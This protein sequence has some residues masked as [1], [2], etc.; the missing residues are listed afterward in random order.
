MNSTKM[1]QVYIRWVLVVVVLL[2][3]G[4]I[5]SGMNNKVQLLPDV[6]PPNVL[7]SVKWPGASENLL[8]TEVIEPYER[9]LTSKLEH[10]QYLTVSLSP[11]KVKFVTTFDFGTDLA[12]AEADIRTLL[13]QIRP[14]PINV[15]PIVYSQGGNNVSNRVVG[16]YFFVSVTNEFSSRQLQIIKAISEQQIANISGID[17]VE[18]NPQLGSRVLFTLD[19]KKMADYAVSFDRV[20]QV[21]KRLFDIPT[22][23]LIQS[24]NAL[25][26]QY[27]GPVQLQ[28]F[29]ST[30]VDF[31]DGTAITLG[32]VATVSIE[33]I[34]TTAAV[35]FNGQK[36]IAVRVL[37]LS[38]ANLTQL[39]Q[40]VQLVLDK[41]QQYLNS[42]GL[43]YQLSYDTTLFIERAI[44][45]LVGS[46]LAGFVLSMLVSYLFFRS[47]APTLLGAGI[48]ILSVCG[49]LILM[50]MLGVSIN[51]ISL[52]GITFAIGMFV[53][54][55][56]IISEYLIRHREKTLL[57]EIK[58]VRQ[59]AP[60]LIASVL[61]TVIVF[62]PLLFNQGGEGQLFSGLAVVIVGGLVLALL[63][64]L[65]IAPIFAFHFFSESAVIQTRES[66]LLNIIA[67][68]TQSW[69]SRIGVLAFFCI[70]GITLGIAVFPPLNY[71][72]SIKRDAIDVFVPL[73]AGLS[74][75]GVEKALVEPLNQAI[76]T[77]AELGEMKNTYV[78]GW[79][80]FVTAALRV[81]DHERIE[82]V[83]AH[84]KATLPAKFPENRVIVMQGNLF[85]GMGD[86]NNIEL[87]LFVRDTRWLA[88]N[89]S[90][91]KKLIEE[92][93]QG[94]RLRFDPDLSHPASRYVMSPKRD[95][96]RDIGVDEGSLKHLLRLIT[97]N[98]YAGLYSREGEAL[99]AYMVLATREELSD[100]GNV[101]FVTDTG[102][103]TYLSA[104]VEFDKR[105]IVPPLKRINGAAVMTIKVGVVDKNQSVSSVVSAL[106]ASVIPPLTQM[107]GDKG[108]I[109]V[110]GSAA[111]LSKAKDFMALMLA[112]LLLAFF[113]IVALVYRS[114]KM[115][116]YVVLTLPFALAGGVVGFNVLNAIEPQGFNILTM[117]GFMIMLGVV[118][119]NGILLIDAIN[120][121]FCRGL[122]LSAAV[123]SGM[124]ERL[125][126]ILVST[127]T[128]VAGMLPLLL[129]QSQAG[130]IYRGLAAVIVGG[131]LANLL[132]VFWVT[133]AAV[134]QF[135]LTNK[136]EENLAAK[137]A[138]Q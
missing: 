54:G 90:A 101:E 66:K 127:I 115:S 61:T 22:G 132:A 1:H 67:R 91:I 39:Q 35:R 18:L 124:Q 129:L 79:G 8:L 72:P 99:K 15:P 64:T 70:G 43:K 59:L 30:P 117:I 60:A 77:D 105:V 56:L 98:D 12:K 28:D 89:Q 88:D 63:L 31:I 122:A 136:Q 51:V 26:L 33:P 96:L 119:N 11:E 57:G 25:Q 135:G 6:E 120:K 73:G 46:I 40:K 84:L 94:I 32:D 50:H 123:D 20:H 103:L 55:V 62:L 87:Q 104:L 107:I 29:A 83:L 125:K 19:P 71:L 38:S 75:A 131:I 42:A 74:V 80:N 68:Y 114:V 36:A 102:Q 92:K 52:A 137:E 78:L 49:T 4:G 27:D 121:A 113:V 116:L 3:V 21:I 16:S 69:F 81:T 106:H 5:Y 93:L 95:N 14:L 7:F 82:T 130:H 85:G 13:S 112:F 134:K 24:D 111:S 34:E 100:Y 48:T 108:Y 47:I 41:N 2:L 65:L 118:S 17:V 138:V 10:L 126:P 86:V 58:R 109:E 133:S 45:W 53:D 110:K 128:T 76:T 37:R 9:L 23:Q 44:A 97:Q